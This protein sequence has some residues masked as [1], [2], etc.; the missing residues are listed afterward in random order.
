MFI[1]THCEYCDLYLH[2]YLKIYGFIGLII[3]WSCLIVS[4]NCS[5]NGE[6]PVSLYFIFVYLYIRL[7]LYL[8]IIV[9]K[10]L[11][12]VLLNT[13]IKTSQSFLTT[14]FD[15]TPKKIAKPS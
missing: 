1:G 13:Y 15:S 10:C 6:S 8:L 3:R 4:Q 14:S 5:D 2:S 12:Y 7:Y 11:P 9:T